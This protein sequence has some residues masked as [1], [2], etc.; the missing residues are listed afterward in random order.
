MLIACNA[1]AGLS[2][3]SIRTTDA[4]V[5]GCVR[6]E[7][8]SAAAESDGTA[9]PFCLQPSGRCVALQS[10]DCNVVTGPVADDDALLIGSLFST[11]GAQAAVNIARQH[12]V[13]LAIEELNSAGGL[14][15]G[16]DAK[17]RPLVLVACDESADL[18]RAGQHLV[19]DLHVPAIIGPNT[20]QDTLNLAS[21]LAIDAGTLLITPTGVASGIA[22]LDDREL[23]WQMAP[24]DTQRAPLMM[25]EINDLERD[26]RAKRNV[27]SLK[28]GI[29]YR[30]DALG[31][32]T[33]AS[34]NALVFNGENVTNASGLVRSDAYAPANKDQSALV[35]AYLDFAPDILVL[36][37]TGEAVSGLLGPLEAGWAMGPHADAP[38]PQY[39]LTD[40]SKVPELLTLVAAQSELAKRVRGTGVTATAES[41]PVR[42]A[43][44]IDYA[45]RFPED[46]DPGS[47]G[48]GTSY[49]ATYAVAYALASQREQGARGADIARGLRRLGNGDRV[50]LQQ[51]TVLSALGA[52]TRGRS[53]AAIGTQAPLIWDQR[54]AVAAGRVEIWCVGSEGGNVFYTAS[55]LTAD[56]ATQAF[57]GENQVCGIN[58]TV[59]AMPEAKPAALPAPVTAG[60]N[61]SAPANAGRTAAAG[62]GGG[63]TAGAA[64]SGSGGASGSTDLGG[65]IGGLFAGTS[66]S[67][68]KPAI[69]CGDNKCSPSDGQYCCV[70]TLHDT[71]DQSVPEDFSCE[72]EPKSCAMTVYCQHDKDCPGDEVCCLSSSAMQCTAAL[73]CVTGH[74]RCNS[75]SECDDSG[76]KCCFS[77][78]TLGTT[79]CDPICPSVLPHDVLVCD[80]D[81]DCSALWVGS[82]CIL[83]RRYPTLHTCSN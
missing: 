70:K 2:E 17:S 11:T 64:N 50:E 42:D 21:T 63:P 83:D 30:D 77:P 54:G 7:D 57:S 25:K 22:E 68:A 51:T 9:T 44:R 36:I 81:A 14:P 75:A 33:R 8:C 1:I 78:A 69:S 31:Q 20:S 28:L 48:L 82:R 10:P 18:I 65:L 52:L 27:S 40:S 5:G 38:R 29:L 73:S 47:S 67:S 76:G 4:A 23:V 37:G 56:I 53:I 6:H 32:G 43:F 24:N 19:S 61:A 80:V 74:L 60:R 34:L 26:L 15:I 39:V 58:P 55:G 46:G 13:M 59:V 49:D 41:V 3:F 35:R 16:K 71:Q 45:V 62:S 72:T 12:S 79:A 66:A